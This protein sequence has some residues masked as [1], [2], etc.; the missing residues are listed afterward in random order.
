MMQVSFLVIVIIVGRKMDYDLVW[1][2]DLADF[3]DGFSLIVSA[4][5]KS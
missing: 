5:L 4:L 1:L 3:D 2:W